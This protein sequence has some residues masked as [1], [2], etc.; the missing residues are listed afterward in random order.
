MTD[1]TVKTTD[2]KAWYKS[3]LVWLGIIMALSGVLPL[4][5]A[6]VA[7]LT[8]A[9]VDAASVTQAVTAFLGG[10]LTVILRVFFTD[11]TIG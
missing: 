4:V 7:S 11:T 2:E 8:A 6:L 3:K 10:A 9:P 5:N 1:E